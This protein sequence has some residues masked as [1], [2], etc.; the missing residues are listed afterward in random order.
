MLKKKGKAVNRKYDVK[1]SRYIVDEMKNTR[2][3][4]LFDR[5]EGRDII[6]A[7]K[8][9]LAMCGTLNSLEYGLG[10]EIA[11]IYVVDV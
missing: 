10:Y 4:D 8:K 11:G 5:V 3:S 6:D 2:I 7:Y 9:A 1:F